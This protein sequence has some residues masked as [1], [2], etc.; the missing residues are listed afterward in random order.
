MQRESPCLGSCLEPLLCCH[1]HLPRSARLSSQVTVSH[2]GP[3]WCDGPNPL[4]ACTLGM[5]LS[6]RLHTS[7]VMLHCS[8][9]CFTISQLVFLLHFCSC[10]LPNDNVIQLLSRLLDLAFVQHFG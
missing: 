2:W 10:W 9:L 8:Q 7:Y 3:V 4:D 6:C 5:S 1:G